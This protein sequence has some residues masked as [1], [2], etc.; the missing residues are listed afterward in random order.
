MSI[1]VRREV[2]VKEVPAEFMQSA[3]AYLDGA[4]KLNTLMCED[5]WKSN[6]YRG[7]VALWLTFHGVELFLKGCILKLDPKAKVAGHSLAVLTKK[8]RTLAPAIEFDPP[9]KVEALPPYPELV[10]D[11]EE[12]EKKTHEVLR[13]PVDLEGEPW[14]GVHGFSAPLFRNTVSRIR[15]DCERVYTQLFE[16]NDG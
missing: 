14:P 12:K 13:Y 9:F 8:L 10:K 3:L 1:H 4:E 5:E 2:S 16:K 6:F 15:L 11:A 7:Q